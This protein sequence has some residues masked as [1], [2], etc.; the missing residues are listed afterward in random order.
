MPSD[1]R[2]DVHIESLYTDNH[3]RVIKE[4][5]NVADDVWAIGDAAI[6]K[7]EL[8]PATAQG[9]TTLIK[10]LRY[11]LNLHPPLSTLQLHRK[12]PNMLRS[13]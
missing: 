4:D 5:G 1:A 3:L 6:I 2:A 11:L 10:L 7:D 9:D 12:K 13:R 8:L